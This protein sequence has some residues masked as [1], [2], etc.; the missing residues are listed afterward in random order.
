MQ[1]FSERSENRLAEAL[2]SSIAVDPAKGM[3][4]R[5]TTRNSSARESITS[6]SCSQR[7]GTDTQRGFELLRQMFRTRTEREKELGQ[8]RFDNTCAHDLGRP[9]E[10]DSH[11]TTRK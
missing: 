1:G 5:K 10:I 7:D 6:T 2:G 11:N 3:D 4:N 9:V 8:H